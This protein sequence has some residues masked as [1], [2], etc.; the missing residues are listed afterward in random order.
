MRARADFSKFSTGA[1]SSTVEFT[2]EHMNPTIKIFEPIL[3]KSEIQLQL[4]RGPQ[5]VVET[6]SIRINISEALIQSA[7]REGVEIARLIKDNSK[8]YSLRDIEGSEVE[9]IKSIINSII[10]SDY[11]DEE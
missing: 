2:V 10:Q 8:G 4:K 11:I 1:D 3:E 6:K 9:K 5:L 7:M